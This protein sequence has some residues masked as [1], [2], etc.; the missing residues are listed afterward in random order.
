MP[1]LGR[2][3][4]DHAVVERRVGSDVQRKDRCR[5]DVTVEHDR[6][7]AVPRG[8]RSGGDRDQF[9][10]THLAQDLQ[11]IGDAGNPPDRL[12]H[13]GALAGQPVVVHTGAAPHPGG[14]LPT[15]AE[16]DAA[17]AD[18]RSLATDADA[19][20]DK[21]IHLDAAEIT[22][23]VTWGTNPGQ[24]IPLAAPVMNAI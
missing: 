9:G 3:V 16:W 4:A 20:F 21:E 1:R 23:H 18:W 17:I 8:D 6:D 10:T 5:H 13:G 24:V 22:P 15:G 19:T 14:R 12:L 7:R 11:W 2:A